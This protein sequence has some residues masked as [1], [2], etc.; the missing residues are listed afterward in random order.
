MTKADVNKQ[1]REALQARDAGRPVGAGRR[2]TLAQFLES[3]LDDSAR[4]KV[5]GTTLNRYQNIVRCSLVPHIG[6]VLL[7][8][9]TPQHILR[10]QRRLLDAGLAPRSVLKARVVLGAALNDAERWGLISRNPVRLTDPPRI[11]ELDHEAIPPE[12]VYGLL[13]ALQGHRLEALF[14]V[15]VALGLRRGEVVG[16]KWE[17]VDLEAGVL[18][19]RRSVQR[20]PRQGL[21]ELELK[22]KTS[23]RDIAL[24][25]LAVAALRA[26]RERQLFERRLAPDAWQERGFVFATAT[27]TPLEPRNVNRS[28]Y[29]AL[30]RAGLPHQRFHDLRHACATLLLLQ[31]E[32]LRVV[33]EV[34]G[35]A[36]YTTTAN[37]YAHVLPRLKRQAAA[38]M[39]AILRRDGDAVAPRL[40]PQASCRHLAGHTFGI[41]TGF[42]EPTKGFEPP[43]R[44]LR[45]QGSPSS[46]V[47]VGPC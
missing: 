43:T 23:R 20:V 36:S 21:Q 7:G 15:A 22:T 34:L 11:P 1:I 27:G 44:A 37:V 39:D 25:G 18:R 40:L 2:Q 4:Q 6:R 47:R 29:L 5:R 19:V 33:Q 9:L 28:L 17:D 30:E 41:R 45:M 26:Q 46:A 35:H 31:G 14:I 13:D 42:G 38:R 16:L 32:D 8:D 24:P 10:L 12:R 3:W